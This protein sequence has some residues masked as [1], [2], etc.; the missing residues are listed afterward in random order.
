[1]AQD[2]YSIL[3]TDQSK[4]EASNM[5]ELIEMAHNAIEEMEEA[6]IMY[7]YIPEHDAQMG[8]IEEKDAKK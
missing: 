3:I 6:A 8:A 2:K 1:M 7:G 5:K 4:V